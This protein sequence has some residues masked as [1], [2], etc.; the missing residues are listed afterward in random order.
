MSQLAEEIKYGSPLEEERDSDSDEF[1]VI[2]I[3]ASSKR[4]K[5]KGKKK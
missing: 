1:D 4:P 5:R 3:G 2:K